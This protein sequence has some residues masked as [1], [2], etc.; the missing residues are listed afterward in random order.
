MDSAKYAW[1][2]CTAQHFPMRMN[3]TDGKSRFIPWQMARARLVIALVST[4]RKNT[5]YIQFPK[6]T[7]PVTKTNTLGIH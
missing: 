4:L 3:S 1:E 5:N 2:S 7:G 6:E